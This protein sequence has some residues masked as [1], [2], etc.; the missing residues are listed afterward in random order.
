[1]VPKDW[2]VPKYAPRKRHPRADAGACRVDFYV[3]ETESDNR[4]GKR[5]N[6]S[7]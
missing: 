1:M 2:V 5:E 7:A 6:V 3:V 4:G